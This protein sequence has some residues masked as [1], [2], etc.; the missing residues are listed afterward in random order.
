VGVVGPFIL[1]PA[2]EL[3]F[4]KATEGSDEAIT[5]FRRADHLDFEGCGSSR[6]HPGGLPREQYFG[7]DVF[8]YL[9]AVAKTQQVLPIHVGF[10]GSSL[11]KVKHEHQSGKEEEIPVVLRCLK[12]L[13]CISRSRDCKERNESGKTAET[14]EDLDRGIGRQG[15]TAA[16]Q[17]KAQDIRQQ[18]EYQSDCTDQMA[19]RKECAAEQDQPQGPTDLPTEPAATIPLE[20]SWPTL[21]GVLHQ[22]TNRRTSSSS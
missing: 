18:P 17:Q 11:L 16:P 1:V 8:Q 5:L 15:S 9:A 13:F 6:E 19:L 12:R 20:L 10:P 4:S 14:D 21:V 22:Q 2:S 3:A 7:T